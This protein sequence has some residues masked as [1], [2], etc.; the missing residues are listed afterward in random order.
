MRNA[1]WAANRRWNHQGVGVD[2]EISLN[3]IYYTYINEIAYILVVLLMYSMGHCR[4]CQL[5]SGTT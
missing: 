4:C 1:T 3:V 2:P 5:Q